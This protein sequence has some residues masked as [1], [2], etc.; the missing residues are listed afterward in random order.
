LIKN[1]WEPNIFPTIPEKQNVTSYW[2]MPDTRENF[3]KNPKP[4]Y[5][6]TSIVYQYNS[7]GF[8]TQEFDVDT[9]VPSILCLGC[10]F[11][12]G[13]GVRVDQAWPSLIQLHFPDYRVYN[14]G[15]GGAP[16]DAM[17][18]ILT[19]LGQ[20]LHTSFVFLLWT[21]LFRYETYDQHVC[22]STN[23]NNLDAWNPQTLTDENMYNVR[24]RNRAMVD[25]LSKLHG[26]TVIEH[27]IME[28]DW[29]V[30][31]GRDEHPGP[32]WH[33]GQA[34]CFLKKFN[35]IQSTI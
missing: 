14:L 13:I 9:I 30:D 1:F 25:M 29:P 24:Q 28:T 15:F 26:Y 7:H 31:F 32:L 23:T 3:L 4:G 18:R 16:G 19:N 21:D 8:R 17:P 20:M 33:V 27:S 34:Q 35:E 10:S 5:T 22:R 11:T 12:E 2:A 6:E